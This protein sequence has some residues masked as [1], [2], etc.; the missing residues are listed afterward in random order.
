M[1][2]GPLAAVNRVDIVVL[3]F[4][5][6][7][8][9]VSVLSLWMSFGIQPELN[10]LRLSSRFGFWAEISACGHSHVFG[11]G[12]IAGACYFSIKIRLCMRFDFS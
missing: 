11:C 7:C 2:V 10:C 12:F 6:T 9:L 5:V 1:L 8:S 3:F 4:C